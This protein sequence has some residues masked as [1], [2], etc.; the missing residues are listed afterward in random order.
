MSEL[1]ETLIADLRGIATTLH[2]IAFGIEKR[3]ESLLTEHANAVLSTTPVPPPQE[4]T[5][6]AD[7]LPAIPPPPLPATGTEAPEPTSLPLHFYPV[8]P[9]PHYEK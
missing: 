1:E 6:H 9:K 5:A 7:A 2:D 4:A 8:A 3:L